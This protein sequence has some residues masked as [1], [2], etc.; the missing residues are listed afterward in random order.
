M[1]QKDKLIARF[2]KKPPPTDFH[3]N[4]VVTLLAGFGFQLH[5]P[6]GGS[7]HKYFVGT[8]GGEERTIDVTKPH[9][10][11]VMKHFQMKNLANALEALGLL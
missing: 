4:E 3:W 1:S 7:S 11:L 8:V 9:P 10:N 5:E 6:K 2:R